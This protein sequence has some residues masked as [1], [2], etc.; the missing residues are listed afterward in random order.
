[1]TVTHI[2]TYKEVIDLGFKREDIHD[3]IYFNQHGHDWFVVTLKLHKNF[4]LNWDNDEGTVELIRWKPK[5]GDILG[6][7]P[8][9]SI[10]EI[11]EMIEFFRKK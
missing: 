3:E 4:Y 8:L 7:L 5:S 10:E 11:K 6:R 9:F 2:I 1:M